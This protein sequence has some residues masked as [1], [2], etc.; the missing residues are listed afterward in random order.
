METY[1]Q[2][3]CPN[4]ACTHRDYKVKAA[5]IGRTA[6]CKGCGTRFILARCSPTPS[7]IGTLANEAP[8][9]ISPPSPVGDEA[10]TQ[11]KVTE[12]PETASL[13]DTST[14]PLPIPIECKPFIPTRVNEPTEA[15]SKMELPATFEPKAHPTHIEGQSI[16]RIKVS[17]LPEQILCLNLDDEVPES[18]FNATVTD[19]KGRRFIPIWLSASTFAAWTARK[20]HSDQLFASQSALSTFQVNSV[21][22]ALL[23]I[24]QN[25][26]D[27]LFID[28]S[29]SDTDFD[30]PDFLIEKIPA[31]RLVSL[32]DYTN[33]RFT[34][35]S[36]LQSRGDWG[37]VAEYVLRMLD[38]D[39]EVSIMHA[40]K[41][42]PA[43]LEAD[44]KQKQQEQ[45]RTALERTQWTPNESGDDFK[46]TEACPK[47]GQTHWI[48]DPKTTGR[49]CLICTR[50]WSEIETFLLPLI[51]HTGKQLGWDEKQVTDRIEQLK[52]VK[53]WADN[54]EP[55]LKAILKCPPPDAC[56]R[57]GESNWEFESLSPNIR[58]ATWRCG[59]CK[60]TELVRAG[61]ATAKIDDDR[62]DAIS[63]EVQREVWRRDHGRCSQCA[64]RENLEFDHV[65]PVSKGGSNTARNV[66]LLCQVCNRRKSDRDPGD[67]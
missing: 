38:Q 54:D 26:A 13:I 20:H 12:A 11:I 5:F 36:F 34:W 45:I 29:E 59:Y 21:Q 43:K 18:E 14:A 32:R 64:S 56:A 15:V 31:N 41:E 55:I 49:E 8:V 63:K 4:P 24:E 7:M 27:F 52:R 53:E 57:C 58:S 50:P 51:Q 46:K 30:R 61:T 25:S 17:D 10:V 3:R 39:H 1:V 40:I 66:Q 19:A 60:R 33:K 22:F 23:M 2:T 67:Y 65:I 62:R 6:A 28:P 42:A 44:L 37:V 35:E 16:A 48:E 9:S 47:C